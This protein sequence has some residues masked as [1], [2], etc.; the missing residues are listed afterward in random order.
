[1]ILKDAED[2][3]RKINDRDVLAVLRLWKFKETSTRFDVQK[4]EGQEIRS[5][6]LGLVS[7]YDGAI[8][9]T[10]PTTD[11]A[12]ATKVLCRRLTDHM[13]AEFDKH[14][15]GWTSINVNS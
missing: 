8:I 9:V 15:F 6:T 4:Y 12:E 5:D 10:A 11:Y 3:G 7:T 2:T 1:M 14:K 13:P